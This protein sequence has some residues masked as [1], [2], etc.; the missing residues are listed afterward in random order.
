MKNFL[1][2]IQTAALPA[3]FIFVS[4]VANMKAQKTLIL[5]PST[6]KAPFPLMIGMNSIGGRIHKDVYDGM[7]LA[8]L[9]FWS[10]Q[11]NGYSQFGGNASREFERLYPQLNGNG[12]YI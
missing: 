11:V 8:Q 7:P 6:G 12:A 5:Y 4:S 10:G 1:S 9:A 2:N 3:S